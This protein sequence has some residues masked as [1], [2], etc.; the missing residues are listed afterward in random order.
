MTYQTICCMCLRET[1]STESLIELIQL[2]RL[3][4]FV[5][6]NFGLSF[7]SSCADKPITVNQIKTLRNDS[8]W[9]Y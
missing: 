1:P 7:C 8:K 5:E 3:L 6:L 4:G 9:S 2:K